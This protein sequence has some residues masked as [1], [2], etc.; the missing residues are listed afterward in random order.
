VLSAHGRYVAF[1]SYASD[2]VPGDTNGEVDVFVRDRVAGTTQRVSV[3]NTGT[4]GNARSDMPALSARG[5]YVAFHSPASNLVLEDTNDSWD[6]FVRDRVAGTTQRVSI[7]DNG[8]Q[9]DG[10]STLPALSAH[11]RY[12]ALTSN[13]PNLVPGDTNQTYDVFMRNRG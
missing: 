9:A 1:G 3:S 13:A 11:G 12:V 6:V 10:T 2:L 8:A 5:R 7:S 4:Q